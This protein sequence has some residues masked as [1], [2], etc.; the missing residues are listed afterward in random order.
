[1]QQY[2]SAL[3]VHAFNNSDVFPPG[4]CV[5]ASPNQSSSD[6]NNCFGGEYT[7]VVKSFTTTDSRAITG[8]SIEIVGERNPAL[9]DMAKGTGGDY[10]YVITSQDLALPTRVNGVQL[11]RSFNGPVT[12][13]DTVGWDGISTDINSGRGGAYLYLVWKNAEV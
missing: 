11:W 4:T 7:Y 6:C 3:T 12:L 10:R 9:Q 5:D 8:L 13:V 1:M 2:I